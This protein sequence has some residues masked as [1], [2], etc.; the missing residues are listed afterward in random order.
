MLMD[1]LLFL[2]VGYL[3]F[4]VFEHLLLPLIWRFVA[5]GRQSC[6]GKEGMVGKTVEVRSWNGEEGRV[7]VGGECWKAISGDHLQPGDTAVVQKVDGLV[8]KIATLKC[9]AEFPPCMK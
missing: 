2:F 5:R 8:L 6:C 9:D 1:A 4:E 7:Q 3:L